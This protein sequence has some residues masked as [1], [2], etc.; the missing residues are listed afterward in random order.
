MSP[1]TWF[2]LIRPPTT[3]PFVVVAGGAMLSLAALD[4]VGAY[5]AKEWS[6]R[7]T[8]GMLALGLLAFLVLFW[9]YAS[10][11]QYTELALVTLGWIVVL[12]VGLL[13]IDRLRYGVHL[14]PGQWVAV[15]VILLAQAYLM[16]PMTNGGSGG[17]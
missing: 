5:A 14:A 1:D 4:L 7:R 15:T 13:L 12:Q 16:L 6:T 9:V 11:L 8:P 10:A 2:P 3:W 17:K